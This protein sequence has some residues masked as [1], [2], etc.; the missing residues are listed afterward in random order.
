VEEGVA[1]LWIFLP[2]VRKKQRASSALLERN[3][4]ELF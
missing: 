4:G 3:L 2:H 1:D